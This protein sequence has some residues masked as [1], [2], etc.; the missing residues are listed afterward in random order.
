M[1]AEAGEEDRGARLSRTVLSLHGLAAGDALGQMMFGR[2]EEA[3]ALISGGDLPAAPWWHTDDTE[4][5]I[6]IVEGL[7]EHGRVEQDALAARFAGRYRQAPDRGYGSGAHRQFRYMAEGV[8]WREAARDA[9]GGEGSLGNGSAMRVAPLGA[10]FADDLERVAKEARASA[11]VTHLHAEGVAGAIAVATAAAM[12]WRLRGDF[13][14]E[15]TKSFI[16]E[17]HRRTREGETR[18]G[19]AKAFEIRSF[20]SPVAAARVLGNGSGITCPDTVP[21]AIWAAAKYRADF[22][23]AIASAAS[24]GGDIDTNCAIVGGIVALSVGQEGI[25]AEWLERIEPLP[26]ALSQP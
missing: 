1:I 7:H 18:Q 23:E 26:F 12:A 24:V 17:V 6:S 21:F 11:M 4:M 2:E 13:S 20:T 3:H 15:A 9:F 5:A 8:S 19:I 22:R 16:V 25:P 10:W 14:A